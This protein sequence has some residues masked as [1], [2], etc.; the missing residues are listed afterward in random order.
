M[1]DTTIPAHLSVDRVEDLDGTPILTGTVT[2]TP[3]V[4]ALTLPRGPAGPAGPK[5]RPRTTFQKMGEITNAA[6][7]PGG[8]GPDDRG[9]W[10]HRL[11]D[12]GMD[13][14]TGTEWRHSANAV[15]P[16]GLI[17]PT[18][19]LA[20]IDTHH[21]VEL[22]AAGLEITGVRDQQ[23]TAT[24][25]AG[26]AGAVGPVGAS[27]AITA[28]PDYDAAAGVANRSMFAFTP[29]GRKFRAQAVPDGY[30]PWSWWQTDFNAS[31]G[32]VAT[33]LLIAGTF[34]VPALPFV[35]RP[36]CYGLLSVYHPASAQVYTQVSVRL[37]TANGLVVAGTRSKWGATEYLNSS[38]GP[39]FA[40]DESPKTLS[41][42]STVA[43][44]PAGQ[45]AT[46]VVCVER[47]GNDSGS[48]LKIGFSQT[49]SS[50]TVFARPI[51][52]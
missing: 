38:Y 11:D 18:P 35:W 17:A 44:V 1:S 10:W 3:A 47:R 45:P 37:G 51:Y 16:Q 34:T 15:G 31:S 20:V 6:A 24:A 5:G 26:L 32:E 49:R 7:R 14:W 52:A 40:D 36:I 46:L 4:A 13:T 2:V 43:T 9:K 27:G 48:T 33:D 23:I 25:P 42:S 29:A 28:S 8:L 19:S 30:G 12:D 41:P 39:L 22:T 21:K 50:L